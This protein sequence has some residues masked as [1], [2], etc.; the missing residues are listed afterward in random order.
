MIFADRAEAGR[1]LGEQVAGHLPLGADRPLVLALP[2]G[3]VPVAAR[4]AERIAGDLDLV[5]ARKIGMPGHPEFGVGAIAEDGT[6]VL[7]RAALHHFGL[8][9]ADLT[10]TVEAERAELA[11]RA[12]RYRGRRPPPT[13]TG[14]VVVVVDDGL[15]TGVTAHAALSWLR[16][17]QPRRLLLAAPV[18]SRS[19][20]QAL[21]AD[22][23]LLVCPH[24]P[25][26]FGAVGQWYT[27][28]RQLS[29]ADV[30]VALTGCA[31]RR[32]PLAPPARR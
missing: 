20:H 23:D 30:D 8:A 16:P 7:D 6:P 24:I 21:A 12:R 15:A 17:Q 13:V 26:S 3:G 25:E 31:A 11:R 9:E 19:A 14:R 18:C 1:V 5:L 4:V 22:A 27:D 2:R 29:D 28:F 32:P 10:E